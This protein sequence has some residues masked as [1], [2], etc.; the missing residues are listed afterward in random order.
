MREITKRI[1]SEQSVKEKHGVI[2]QASG[3]YLRVDLLSGVVN[4]WIF[5]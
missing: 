3:E 4:C 1:A 2:K 5:E